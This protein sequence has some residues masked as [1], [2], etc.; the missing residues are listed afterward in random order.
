MKRLI[1]L[2]LTAVLL[3]PFGAAMAQ[4]TSVQ[5]DVFGRFVAAGP[6]PTLATCGTSST[7]SGNDT[8][9][10][11]T[12]GTGTPSACT[13]TFS[14]AFAVAPS[15]YAVDETTAAKNAV[16]AA[17]TTTAVVLTFAAATVNSD[18]IAYICIGR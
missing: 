5:P 14:R 2:L 11:I 13:I 9:G 10:K 3:V 8:A 16:T 18:V 4:V 12:I 7:V 15:C 1:A 17:S 6:A